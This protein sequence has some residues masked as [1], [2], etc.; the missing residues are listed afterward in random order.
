ML[1]KPTKKTKELSEG[2]SLKH[3]STDRLRIKGPKM[4]WLLFFLQEMENDTGE[5]G[6]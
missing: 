5:K 6:T 3:S 2:E 4:L 1:Q